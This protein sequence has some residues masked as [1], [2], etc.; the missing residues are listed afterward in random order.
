MT[1]EGSGACDAGD[2]P[3]YLTTETKASNRK[4]RKESAKVRKEENF[5]VTLRPTLRPLRLCRLVER[6]NS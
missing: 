1:V 6:G 5:A 3:F 4:G 2:T